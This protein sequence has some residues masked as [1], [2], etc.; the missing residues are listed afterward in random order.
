MRQHLHDSLTR[1]FWLAG[2]ALL[3][4]AC[5]GGSDTPTSPPAP[6]P[7]GVVTVEIMDNQF[8]PRSVQIEPGQTVRWVFRGSAP[9]HTVTAEDGSFDS[10]AVFTQMGTAFERTFGTQLANQTI[11]YRCSS[12]YLCCQMQGSVRVGSGAPPPNPGY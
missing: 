4:G 8:S 7:A 5:G 2:L 6:G 1:I 11:Q 3:A 10:G 9:G 12:H